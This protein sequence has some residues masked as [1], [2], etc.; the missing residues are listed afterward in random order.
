IRVASETYFNKPPDSLNIQESAVLVGML[1]AITRFNPVLNPEN[2][3]SKRNEVIAK[4]Y[5]H[6]Y[7]KSKEEYDSIKALPIQLEYKVQNQ[8]VGLATYF[9]RVLEPELMVWAKERGIDLWESGLK[10]YTTLDSRMQQYA[11]EAMEEHM[12]NLQKDF[13]EHWKGRNPWLDDDWHEIKGF[14]NMRIKQTST[15]KALVE[16][17][18]AGSDS[19]KIM[20]NLKKPMRIFTWKGERD[21]LFSSIDSL[22]YYKRFLH[23][24]FVAMDAQT[25]A[26]KAWVGGINH[27][28]FKYDH[29]KQGKRQ[30]GSTFKPFVYGT[31]MEAGYN[32]CLNKVDVSPSIPVPGGVWYPP[33]SSG[34]RGTGEKMTLRQAMARSVNSITAQVMM[35][36]GPANVV[37]FAKRVGITSPLEPVPSLCLGVNDVSLFELVGAYGT[38]VNS[39]IY[40]QP[41]YITRIEDKNGNV[42]ENFVPKTREAISEQTAFK[43]IYMLQGG[44][45]E[46]GGTSRGLPLDLKIDNEIGG[47]TGTTNNASDGWYMGIT[48]NLVAGAWVGG[49]ERSIHY[50]SWDMGTGSRTARP[51]WANFMKKVYADESLEYKKGSFKRPIRGMDINLDCSKYETIPDSLGVVEEPWQIDDMN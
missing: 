26:V 50:R 31:A 21:T 13:T 5:K 6:R 51:I 30:P 15:Y 27:K 25:G 12:A 20:L 7:I 39:G 42:I 10:I 17:Y 3:L 18:G 33:N 4:L 37:A 35:E 49:D 22:N 2:A 1:Q 16:K 24:G 8:N 40:T 32:P 11:E 34:D 23:A 47:K 48:H 46:E 45:V 9:R 44:V 29:V 38:F 14:L 19:V 28:Y 36:V 41:Y 43:M